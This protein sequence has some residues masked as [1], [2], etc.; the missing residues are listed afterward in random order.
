MGIVLGVEA[1]EENM[2]PG[3]GI[4]KKNV[5]AKLERIGLVAISFSTSCSL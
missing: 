1:G 2:K 4:Y 3:R 5:A